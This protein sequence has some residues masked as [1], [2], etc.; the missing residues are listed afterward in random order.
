MSCNDQLVFY[1]N[2][3][4]ACPLLNLPVLGRELE[5]PKGV[6]MLLLVL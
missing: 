2:S 5:A 1:V 4:V 3:G 6:R